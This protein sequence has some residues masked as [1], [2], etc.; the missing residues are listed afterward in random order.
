MK[1]L[2]ECVGWGDKPDFWDIAAITGDT[3]AQVYN[4]NPSTGCEYCVSGYL[5]EPEYIKYVFDTCGYSHEYVT[6]KELNADNGRY[7]KKI[8]EMIERDIPILVKTNLYDMP[9]W[10]SD[11]GTHCLI[12][13]YDHG[14]QVVKLYFQGFDENQTSYIDCILS[15]ENKM[16]LIFIGEKQRE[17]TLEELYIKAIQKMTHW[18]T[19]P[20]SD[21]KCFGAAAFRAWAD[22]IEAGRF[23]DENLPLWENYGVYVCNLATSGGGIPTNIFKQLS[24]MNPSYQHLLLIYERVQEIMSS[25]WQNHGDGNC[26]IWDKLESLKSGMNM[27]EV[28]VT[29]RDKEKRSKVV[30]VLRDYAKR[31]DKVVELLDAGL[32]L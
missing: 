28:K 29:M 25:G 24:E 15:G 22:D 12:V 19:L 7:I 2:L 6:A 21:G 8:V 11:V 14:G 23:E 20:E 9:D 31:I 1:F 17:V 32:N 18:L 5:A 10:D 4:R 13:G 26:D 27:D 16:D 3:V 30:A